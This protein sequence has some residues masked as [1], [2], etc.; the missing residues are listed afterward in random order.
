[1]AVVGDY[2]HQ[3]AGLKGWPAVMPLDYA[4]FLCD[5]ANVNYA[6]AGRAGTLN[7][8]NAWTAG[9]TGSSTLMPP[10]L[11]L[12]NSLTSFD[13]AT[14]MGNTFGVAIMPSGHFSALVGYGSFELYTSEFDTTLAT[15]TPGMPLKSPTAAQTTSEVATTGR[16]FNLKNWNGGGGGA[17]T[18]GTETVIGVA[19]WGILN[20][21]SSTASVTGANY[22]NPYGVSSLAFWPVYNH[23][24]A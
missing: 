18:V 1:M 8:A 11:F 14:N 10:P 7:T 2:T 17:V 19:A 23:G 12:L 5:P 21:G 15:Y 9:V 13:V 3:I 6:I 24:T 16:L 20:A 22:T 4:P